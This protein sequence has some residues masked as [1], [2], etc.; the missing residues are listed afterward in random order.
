MQRCPRCE[1][2]KP[3]SEFY[4]RADRKGKTHSYCKACINLQTLQRQRRLKNQCI[5]Y[6]GGKCERCGITGHPA[7]FDFH[8][9]DPTQKDF[10]LSRVRSLKF[11]TMH[12]EELDKCL[13]LCA[14]CHRIEH[15]KF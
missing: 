8:H 15:A 6:K 4:L 13:L 5:E 14:N 11:S 9:K 12:M 1:I 2:F 10:I 7:I 3:I